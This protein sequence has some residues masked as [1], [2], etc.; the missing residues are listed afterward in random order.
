MKAKDIRTIESLISEYGMNSGVSTPTSQQKTGATAKTTAAAKPPKPPKSGVNKPQVSPSSQQ[1]K[2]DTEEPAP[3]E[4]IISKAKELAQDFEYQ[5]DKGDTV[6]VMSPV[7]NGLNK[8]AVVVQNQNNKE[9]YT[10][11]PED[12]I[13]LPGEEEAVTERSDLHKGQKRKQK[14]KSRIKRLIRAQK[15]IQQGDPIF[16]INFNSPSVAKDSLNANIRCG[17]EAE[18]I[19]EGFSASDDDE[20][21]LYGENWSGVQ[22]LIYDQE[23]SR[24]VSQIEDA[25]REWLQESD[26]FYDYESEVINELVDE[27]KEDPD[28]LDNYVSY[29]VDMD[30]VTNYKEMILQGLEDQDD[31]QSQEEIEERSDWEEDAWAREYVDAEHEDAFLE[32]LADD[33][34]DNGEQWDE[35][36]DR[37]LSNVDEDDWC[38]EEYNGNW[39]S[40]LS[41]YDIYLYSESQGSMEEVADQIRDWASSKSHTSEVEAGD[42]HSGK[43]VDNDY[44]RVEDDSSIEGDG[45]GAEIIS[46]VYDTPTQMLA[47]MKSLFSHWSD[48]NVDTNRSTGLHVTMSMAGNQEAPNKLKIALL[49]GDKYLLQQFNRD[50]NSYTKSQVK[51]IQQYMQNVGANYKDEKNLSALEDMLKGGISAG[52]FTSINFKDATNDDGNG[53]IEFR[54]AGGDG[55]HMD[56][57]TVAKTTIRYAAVMRAGHDTEA[58][59]KDYIKALFRFVNSLDAID[60]DQEERASSRIDP[61]NTDKKV[62]DAFKSVVGKNHYTDAIDALATAYNALAR[63]KRENAE[64]SIIKEEESWNDRARDYSLTAFGYLLS[65]IATGKNRN[66]V[67]VQ[68]VAGFRQAMKDFGFTPESLYKEFMASKHYVPILNIGGSPYHDNMAKFADAFNNAFKVKVA[69]APTPEFSVKYNGDDAL[70]LPVPYYNWL[71]TEMGNKLMSDAPIKTPPGKKFKPEDF[72]TINRD[73]HNEV[74]RA[75]YDY[76]EG[77]IDAQGELKM[78]ADYEKE[79]EQLGTTGTSD[80]SDNDPSTF[81]NQQALQMA[82]DD[83]PNFKLMWDSGFGQFMADPNINAVKLAR[84][85]NNLET[86]NNAKQDVLNALVYN[87]KNGG[88]PIQWDEVSPVVSAYRAGG[89]NTQESITN[90]DT[91]TDEKITRI[92]ELIIH[93]K[94]KVERYQE[95]TLEAKV[96]IDTFMK[97]HGFLPYRDRDF[98]P[99]SFSIAGEK[100]PF[101]VGTHQ[102]TD[103]SEREYMAQEMNIRFSNIEESNNMFENFNKLPFKKQLEI[104]S[105]VDATKINEALIVSKKKLN[106]TIEAEQDM[107][108]LLTTYGTPGKKKKKGKGFE[109]PN[110][111]G[112]GRAAKYVEGKKDFNFDHEDLYKLQGMDD[113][114]KIKAFALSLISNKHSSRQMKPEKVAWFDAALDRTKSKEGV[115]KMMWDLLLSG[116]GHGVKGSRF[117]TDKNNYRTVMGEGA[118]PDNSPERKI[119]QLLNTPMLASD[120][121]AQMEAYFVIPDPSMIKAFRE[122]SSAGSPN[123]DLRSIFRSFVQNKAHPVLKKKVGITESKSELIKKLEEL[124][125]DEKTNKLINYMEQLLTDMGVGGKIQSLSSQLGEVPDEDVKKAIK[126]IA[127]IIA[128]IEMTPAERAKL[129]I[130][131]KGDKLVRVDT[132]LSTSTD[133]MSEIFAG[134]GMEGNEHIT[135][136]VDDLNEVVQYGIGPGEFA[137]SVL[138]QRISGMG[139]SSGADDGKGDLMIDGQPIEL[140]T[141]RKNS[142][143]FN[144][145]Q[146]TVSDSYKSKVTAFFT[147]YDEKFKELEAQGAVLRVKSGMQQN[148][149]AAFLNLVPEAEKEIADII[150]NIFTEIP[151]AGNQIAQNLAQNNITG[152]M[153]AIA[154]SNVNNYLAAKRG[155]GN[156][157]GILFLDLKKQTFT[158]I[159]DVKDLEG[160]GLRLHAKTNYLVTTNE[161]PFAN[162]SIVD[163]SN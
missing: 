160:S 25:F 38:N 95:Q 32:W 27:R 162:T 131:W 158:F 70:F 26:K 80:A 127:K 30:D 126:Q 125:D 151:N 68:Q 98:N 155:G 120:L 36:W 16:E 50:G 2:S 74:Y 148:H 48:R 111:S 92:K 87:K 76:N 75:L 146:V 88:N 58:F 49:L 6:K 142:A 4:P 157:K 8:D 105:K 145:R 119:K 52:K 156:L 133:T 21:F 14:I 106:E 57:D 23:G 20:D 112:S 132:L 42:Y 60:P 47:E 102:E 17:F 43:Q 65:S 78:V 59:R 64:E 161:N 72:K 121:K 114:S 73:E 11:D 3:V 28:Y 103:A 144:D 128:S 19:W 61:D 159:Q 1:N 140:K 136:L 15:Y 81:S 79:L 55:Y 29:E 51:E 89:V 97:K 86:S 7:N 104:I 107:T 124:P 69:K 153:Q 5:D 82:Q 100:N 63:S 154:Q 84:W 123:T 138:S 99:D 93:R 41:D 34:R 54:I 31:R 135:E 45:M 35:A 90:E 77:M 139:A 9:F 101:I 24:S 37:A 56:F 143:R 67:K 83:Y 53:L 18:T 117:S 94:Q 46:P 109:H 13:T 40:L 91:E 129:F 108:A 66:P 163:S 22:D 130:D 147:K 134:Y 149:V 39:A 137:L 44:W 116:E 118:V 122:A 12:D 152:A 71:Q 141:T 110:K 115:V 10:L 96:K 85:I 62:V 33:I 150:S 113:L